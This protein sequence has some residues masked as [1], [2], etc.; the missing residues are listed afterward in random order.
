[1]RG[2]PTQEQNEPVIWGQ[3]SI[4][5]KPA[6]PTKSGHQQDKYEELKVTLNGGNPDGKGAM[7]VKTRIRVLT[8]HMN[9]V[10]RSAGE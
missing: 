2:V 8:K 10:T 4:E 7:Q 6:P 1:M 5:G 3:Q 9:K